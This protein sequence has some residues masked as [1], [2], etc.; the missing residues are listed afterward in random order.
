MKENIS[1]EVPL[2]NAENIA[3]PEYD[4]HRENPTTEELFI[5]EALKHLSKEQRVIW[6][7]YAY[8]KLTQDEI[9][10]K[11]GKAQSSIA[12]RI[13]TIEKQVAKWVKNNMGAYELLKKEYPEED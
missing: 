10:K 2:E 1:R 7:L 5:R 8:D 11:L 4:S 6:E 9:A 13:T 3:A 12:R